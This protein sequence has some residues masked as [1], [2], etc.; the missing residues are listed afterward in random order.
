[1]TAIGSK[2]YCETRM[3][4]IKS[5]VIFNRALLA[6]LPSLGVFHLLVLF[7]AEIS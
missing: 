2:A 3:K 4:K 7:V 6:L 5:F 1:M